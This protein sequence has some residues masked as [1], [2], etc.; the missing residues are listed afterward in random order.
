MYKIKILETT[1]YLEQLKKAALFHLEQKFL[2][3]QDSYQ[4][5]QRTML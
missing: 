5:S 4:K 1:V 2:W 3:G